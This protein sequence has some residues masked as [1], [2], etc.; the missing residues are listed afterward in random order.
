MKR[1]WTDA[2]AVEEA[3]GWAIFLDSRPLRTPARASLLLP[4]RRLADAIVEEW[5][6]SPDDV[7]P[8][9]MPLTGLANAA[10]DRIASDQGTFAAGVAKYA[11]ADLICYRVEGPPALVARQH[12]HWDPLLAWARKR[13]DVEFRVTT[14]LLHVP[15]PDETVRRLHQEV[16]ALEPLVLAGLSQLVTIGGS[17]LAGLAIVEQALSVHEAWRAVSID[18]HWQLEQ[19]GSDAEAEFALENRKR[20]FFV[21]AQFVALL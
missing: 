20:D 4:S 14:A 1:F 17:L 16:S 13:F 21:A 12:E 6:R 19:W 11:E 5:R 8:R 7:N 15:Q 2:E 3:G 10:V 18:E 9:E